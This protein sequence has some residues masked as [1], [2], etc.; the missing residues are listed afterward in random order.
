ML[1]FYSSTILNCKE[2][3]SPYL[4]S[5]KCH[6]PTNLMNVLETDW[7]NAN[8]MNVTMKILLKNCSA[9]IFMHFREKKFMEDLPLANYIFEYLKY[10]VEH[11]RL[12]PKMKL[13]SLVYIFFSIINPKIYS[14]PT[15]NTNVP[16]AIL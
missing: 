5:L 2:N 16:V 10:T 15:S 8:W 3:S 9:F 11:H 14:S 7:I 12:I 4:T 1:I 6:C 13:N